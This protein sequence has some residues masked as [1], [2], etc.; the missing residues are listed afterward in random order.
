ML[1]EFFKIGGFSLHSYGAMVAFGFAARMLMALRLGRKAGIV[2]ERVLDGVLWL[3]LSSIV[4]ARIFYVIEFHR[5]FTSIAEVFMIWKGG[6]VIYGGM[7]VGALALGI[8]SIRKKL[9]LLTVLDIS[10][11]AFSVGYAIGRIGCFLNGCCF[12][13]ECALPWAV[14][15]PGQT[16]ARHPVQLYSTVIWIAVFLILL[17]LFDKKRFE[18]E[19]FSVGLVFYSVYRFSIEFL[20][21]N[22]RYFMGL[23]EAQLISVGIFAMAIGLYGIL[24]RRRG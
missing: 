21:M 19:V 16:A 20:R 23:S 13:S 1:P 5:D 24:N 12:G 14:I 4:G 3:M 22:P 7:I 17:E 8:F 6:L 15:F 9:S 10:A 18:G 11:P 2:A